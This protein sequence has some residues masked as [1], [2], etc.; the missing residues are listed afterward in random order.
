MC[1]SETKRE[2]MDVTKEQLSEVLC[3][4]TL[5]MHLYQPFYISCLGESELMNDII[6]R[7][8]LVKKFATFVRLTKDY[9]YRNHI[10][11][12]LFAD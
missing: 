4:Q 1:L 9:S 8:G 11:F 3:K 6:G 10:I 5:K 12:T 7:Y 2:S